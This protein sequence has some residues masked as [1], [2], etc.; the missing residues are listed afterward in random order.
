MPCLSSLS[1]TDIFPDVTGNIQGDHTVDDYV[2]ASPLDRLFMRH[3]DFQ[4]FENIVDWKA[5]VR[6]L[7]DSQYTRRI[8]IRINHES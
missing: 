5:P 8:H 7:P 4:L 3:D 6:D 1:L 2:P